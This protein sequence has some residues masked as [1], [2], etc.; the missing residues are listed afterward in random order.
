M[1][2]SKREQGFGLLVFDRFNPC[3]LRSNFGRL[4]LFKTGSSTLRLRM[5]STS[6]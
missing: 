2:S 3:V 1:L 5:R 6:I 4:V